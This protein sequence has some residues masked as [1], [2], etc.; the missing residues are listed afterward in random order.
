MTNQHLITPPHELVKQ[1]VENAIGPDY[2]Q[3]IA[4]QAAR[5]GADRELEACVKWIAYHPPVPDDLRTARRPTPPSLKEQALQA[6]AELAAECYGN[7][8]QSDTIR[9]ALEKLYD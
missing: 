9:R 7:T 8:D 6:L 3:V 5:W 1:W 4:T 2:E